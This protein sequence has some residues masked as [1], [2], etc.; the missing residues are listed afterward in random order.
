MFT[1][2][3]ARD[4]QIYQGLAFRILRQQRAP[5][6]HRRTGEVRFGAARFPPAAR[7]LIGALPDAGITTPRLAADTAFLDNHG[8]AIELTET[9]ITAFTDADLPLDSVEDLVTLG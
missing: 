3:H 4:A 6:L 7:Q 2:S 5:A 9:M 1:R 8:G